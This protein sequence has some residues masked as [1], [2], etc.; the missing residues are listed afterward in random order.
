[1]GASVPQ[2]ARCRAVRDLDAPGHRGH[3]LLARPR[4]LSDI[5]LFYV[6]H[7]L[8]GRPNYFRCDG[9]AYGMEK[10]LVVQHGPPPL[11]AGV[12]RVSLPETR[13]RR[14]VTAAAG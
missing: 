7:L 11:H 10:F 6:L 9:G 12:Q 5:V 4:I 2:W 14:S 13:Y 1:M 3:H 8:D